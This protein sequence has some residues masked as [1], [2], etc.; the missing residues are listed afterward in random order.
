MHRAVHRNEVSGGKST[1]AL[2]GHQCSI[3]CGS[4]LCCSNKS[5]YSCAGMLQ[6]LTAEVDP[7][8]TKIKGEFF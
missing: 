1:G 6:P 8:H 3:W 7:T 5:S 4:G 2:G